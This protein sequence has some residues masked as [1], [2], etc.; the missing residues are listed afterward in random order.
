MLLS[1]SSLRAWHYWPDRVKPAS[2][3]TSR[4]VVVH[5]TYFDMMQCIF[6][7]YGGGGE[8]GKQHNITNVNAASLTSHDGPALSQLKVKV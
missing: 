4:L 1:K 3:L 5:C 7:S 8:K 6:Q 2:Q